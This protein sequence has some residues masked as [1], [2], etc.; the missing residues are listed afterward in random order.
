MTSA[1][2]RKRCPPQRALATLRIGAPALVL[3]AS[4]TP[5]PTSIP[6]TLTAP[7]PTPTTAPVVLAPPVQIGAAFVYA[8]GAK[9]VAVPHGEFVMGYGSADNPEHAVILSDYWLYAAE[10]TNYQYSLCVNQ[11]SCNP[12]DAADNPQYG[13]FEALNKPVVGVTHEQ[14]SAYCSFVNAELPTE[15][16]WEKAARGD[17]GRPYPWGNDEPACALL[18]F[19]GCTGETSEVTENEDGSSPYGALN[20]AGNVYEWVADWYDPVY[21]EVSPNGD[22]QGPDSGRGR[23]VRS[24][25]FRSTADQSLSYARSYRSPNDHQPDLGFRCAVG[26]VSY[27]A[28]ACTLAPTLEIS[29]MAGVAVDCPRIS[30]HVQISAC[31]YGGGAIVT[32]EN[33]HPQDPKASFGGIVGCTLLSGAPGSYPLAYECRHASTAVM[34]SSCTFSGVPAGSCPTN[35]VLDPATGLCTW[36]RRSSLGIDCPTGEF[37]DPVGHCCRITTGNI[38]DFPACPIGSVFTETKAESYACLPVEAA[39]SSPQ[40]TAAVN[41]PVCGDVCDLTVALCSVRNLVFCPTTC[42]CLAVGR[43]CPEP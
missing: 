9:L 19:G 21:Y 38:V 23:V 29:Q 2:S 7:V 37:Y 16:Q 12:P 42:S 41:P 13:E 22:P 8:D 32:F 33:D 4:C 35:Y 14:A 34:S 18:N 40:V 28:P 27:F 1:T 39:R 36:Q 10:V 24:S 3:L 11:G 26:D 6:V 20:M 15:A 17:D 31:R 43:K 25:G 30:I 5:P